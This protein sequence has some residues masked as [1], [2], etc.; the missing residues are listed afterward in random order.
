MDC[1]IAFQ[2]RQF[3]QLDLLNKTVSLVQCM[4][5]VVKIWVIIEKDTPLIF[6]DEDEYPD[7]TFT[8]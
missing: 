1:F 8:S 4:S 7:N 2:N 3:D 6:F 5:H